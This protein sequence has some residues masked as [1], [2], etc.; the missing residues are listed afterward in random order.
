MTGVAHTYQFAQRGLLATWTS[1]RLVDVLALMA[2]ASILLLG[3]F[4]LATHFGAPASPPQ[5]F[6]PNAHVAGGWPLIP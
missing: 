4:V 1:H 5:R 2:S 6:E 3:G